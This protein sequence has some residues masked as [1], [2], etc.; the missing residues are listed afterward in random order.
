LTCLCV[1]YLN[2]FNIQQATAPLYVMHFEVVYVKRG[3][4]DVLKSGEW[5]TSD[6]IVMNLFLKCS[7]QHR[8]GCTM[9]YRRVVEVRIELPE[10]AEASPPH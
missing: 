4:E 10:R 9:P 1:L 5:T 6:M 3:K 2:Y 7:M 8:T